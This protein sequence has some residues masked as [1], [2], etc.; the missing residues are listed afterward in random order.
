MIA[1]MTVL[2]YLFIHMNICKPPTRLEH[3]EKELGS[4]SGSNTE[5][6]ATY[7]TTV[8]VVVQENCE[9]SVGR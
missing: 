8:H 2:I 1:M 9:G 5:Y 7:S 4:G 3:F 6:H